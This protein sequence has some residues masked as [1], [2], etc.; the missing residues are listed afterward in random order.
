MPTSQL[1]DLRGARTTQFPHVV[2]QRIDMGAGEGA[3][4]GQTRSFVKGQ[5]TSRG[6]V[7]FACLHPTLCMS[8]IRITVHEH[9]HPSCGKKTRGLLRPKESGL[10]DSAVCSSDFSDSMRACLVLTCLDLP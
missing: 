6:A 4:F 10:F 1:H 8:P 7:G 2:C 5:K 9:L 3:A